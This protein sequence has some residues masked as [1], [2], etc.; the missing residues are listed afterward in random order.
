MAIASRAAD[1]RSPAVSSM[2]S[3]R[4]GGIG[5]TC[6]ARSSSSSVVSPMAEMTM[7]TSWPAL[8]VATTRWATR[9]MRVG[10]G[11]RGAA[12]L[13]HDQAHD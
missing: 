2:S 6:W 7:T 1:I 9:L 3:S 11:D 8:R 13:L 4:G 10:V 12:V 5:E